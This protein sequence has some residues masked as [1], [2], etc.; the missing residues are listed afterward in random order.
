MPR[1]PN[2]CILGLAACVA[3]P[4][5]APAP[6]QQPPAGVVKFQSNTQL[7]VE[8]VTVKDKSGNTIE[9]L[10]AR[11]FRG[12]PKTACRRPSVS[13][14][15]RSCRRR[16]PAPLPP[17]PV[18]ELRL[19]QVQAAAPAR[20]A[21]EAAGDLHYRDRRLLVLYFDMSAMPPQDQLRAFAAALKFIRTQMTG[22]D[23]LAIMQ[24][25][26]GAVKV[27]QDFTDD[28]DQ[29]QKVIQTLILADQGLDENAADESAADTGA[30]FGQDDAEFNIFNTD[31]QLAAL[32]TAVKMLGTLNEKKSLVY[33]ASGLRLNGID[34]QAQ[35]RATL[36]AAIRVQR[37]VLSD[38]RAR[39]GGVGAAGRCH[40]GIAGRHGHV[41]RR[42]GHGGD[43]QLPALAG[44]A[45]RAG[46]GHR[47][48]GHAR[49]QRSL[50]GDRAGA[51]SV[52]Q[53]LPHRILHDQHRA[54]RQVPAHSHRR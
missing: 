51:E 16:Q 23:L 48:Q 19:D 5:Q 31:R 52:H 53:L 37:V 2:I 18:A 32:Q 29:L 21:P 27:L 39:P 40:A 20:I 11:G 25:T 17:A 41:H 7:V 42:R 47:R 33:F 6:A 24:Y 1:I 14:S 49:L 38:R 8:V 26:G 35:L 12:R 3:F 50:A 44:Y 9:G 54:G 34:N 46:G 4:Q 13:A 10:T 36:N 43:E 30:A 45:V 22:P 15:T 28:R